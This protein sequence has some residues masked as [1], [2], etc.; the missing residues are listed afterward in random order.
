MPQLMTEQ[1]T[2]HTLVLTDAEL[3]A[4][5]DAARRALDLAGDSDDHTP[6]WRTIARLGLPALRGDVG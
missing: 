1:V 3:D 6:V 4:W 5:R 2:T